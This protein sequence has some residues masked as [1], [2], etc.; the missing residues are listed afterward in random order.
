MNEKIKSYS[1]RSEELEMDYDRW[2]RWWTLNNMQKDIGNLENAVW[3][4]PT[5]EIAKREMISVYTEYEKLMKSLMKAAKKAV[6]I[7]DTILKSKI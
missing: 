1:E 7:S 4:D 3:D 2:C 6:L 5:D